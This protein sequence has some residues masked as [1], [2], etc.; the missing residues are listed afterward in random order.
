VADLETRLHGKA[1]FGVV[2]S[3]MKVKISGQ[4]PQQDIT[5]TLKLADVGKNAKSEFPD[6]D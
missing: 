2:T 3:K 6:A 4:G 1:P 5:M